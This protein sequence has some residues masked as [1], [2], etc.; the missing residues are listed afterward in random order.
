MKILTNW[1]ANPFFLIEFYRKVFIYACLH[2]ESWYF[3]DLFVI[4]PPNILI[5]FL[6]VKF[7]LSHC[8]LIFAF[9][10]SL[11]TIILISKIIFMILVILMQ[12]PSANVGIGSSLAGGAAENILG[13]YKV[14]FL[15][16]WII[17]GILHIYIFCHCFLRFL[18]F[19]I[20]NIQGYHKNFDQ[21]N[22]DK[23]NIM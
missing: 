10:S 4:S 13:R 2:T 9:F 7:K 19:N 5:F 18:T 3:A 21:Y 14:N 15:T 22:I 23:N 11:Q 6:L 17:K 16:R 1:Y 8:W 12:N 20:I